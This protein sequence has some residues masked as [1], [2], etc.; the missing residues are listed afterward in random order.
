MNICVLCWSRQA[1]RQSELLTLG[2]KYSQFNNQKINCWE[3]QITATQQ[4]FNTS[5]NQRNCIYLQ[6]KT[7]LEIC[8]ISIRTEHKKQQMK[9]ENLAVKFVTFVRATYDWLS[10]SDWLCRWFFSSP[11]TPCSLL[12]SCTCLEDDLPDKRGSVC[13]QEYTSS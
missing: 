3:L 8:F 11:N 7:T 4:M 5:S 1:G 12:P 10:S 6:I 13:N 9:C 2:W